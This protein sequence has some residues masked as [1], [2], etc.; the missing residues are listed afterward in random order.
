MEGHDQKVCGPSRRTCAHPFSLSNSILLKIRFDA[1]GCLQNSQPHA[2]THSKK[3]QNAIHH[4]CICDYRTRL[5]AQ[6]AEMIVKQLQNRGD[7]K[8]KFK[9]WLKTQ[10]SAITT[11]HSSQ[12]KYA[13][14]VK[15]HGLNH[16]QNRTSCYTHH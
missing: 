13:L 4:L 16:T 1:T 5:F 7:R 11:V 10:C 8:I 3:K 9:K 15:I 6:D 14:N 2:V 12:I